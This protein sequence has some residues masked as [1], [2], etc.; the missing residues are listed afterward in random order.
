MHDRDI[1]VSTHYY[2]H[3]YHLHDTIIIKS[4]LHHH[5]HHHYYYHHYNHHNNYR[6]LKESID[7]REI[8]SMELNKQDLH[9]YIIEIT[10]LSS[11]AHTNEGVI[12]FTTE[13]CEL[14]EQWYQFLNYNI[15]LHN[16]NKKKIV[17]QKTRSVTD[18]TQ[19]IHISG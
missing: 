9:T 17:V 6:E 15:N 5:H 10:C 19:R 14:T 3:R 2:H 11:Q 13:D 12:C 8:E 16:K 18:S 1:I 4:L 7:F